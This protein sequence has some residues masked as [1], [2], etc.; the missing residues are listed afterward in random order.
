[1]VQVGTQSN[2][3]NITGGATQQLWYS[4][5]VVL[6]VWGGNSYSTGSFGQLGLN[7]STGRIY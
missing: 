6:W 7:T 3:T 1:M 4:N 2:W 5:M